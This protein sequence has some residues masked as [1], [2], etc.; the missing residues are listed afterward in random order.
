LWENALSRSSEEYFKK[1]VDPDVDANE[2]RNS[3]DSSMFADTSLSTYSQRS[4]E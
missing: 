2:F 1:F 4:S 3:I